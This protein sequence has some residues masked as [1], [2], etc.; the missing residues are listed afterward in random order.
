[1]QRL[2][3]AAISVGFS[4]GD[5]AFLAAQTVSCSLSLIRQEK[6]AP[7]ILRERVASKGG[8][9]EAGLSVLGKGGSWDEAAQ[10]ALKRA[11]ELTKGK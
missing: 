9:T 4:Q 5:A 3:R 2:Q 7:A 1:M 6:G 8:T 11:K 10:A